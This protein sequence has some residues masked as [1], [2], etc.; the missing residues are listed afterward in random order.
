MQLG[1]CFHQYGAIGPN[2][3]IVNATNGGQ[4]F[5]AANALG[6]QTGVFRFD[7]FN[8][9]VQTAFDR[10]SFQASMTLST[11]SAVNGGTASNSTQ[12]KTISVGWMRELRPDMSLSASA[13]YSLIDR[14]T[15]TAAGGGGGT[16]KSLSTAVGLQYVLSDTATASARYTFFGRESRI[17]GYGL[18]ENILLLGLTKQF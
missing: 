16:D 1:V 15:G 3:Q 7:T 17:P 11:Q 2:G 4:L 13:S 8:A 10:S 6:A 5:G 12:I 9:S 14:S 18:F